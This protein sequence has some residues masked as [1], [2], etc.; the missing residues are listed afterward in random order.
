M[1]KDE[2]TKN[3]ARLIRELR[4]RRKYANIE[5]QQWHNRADLDDIVRRCLSGKNI[6]GRRIA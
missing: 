1:S 3:R 4:T 5:Y 2:L 6:Q